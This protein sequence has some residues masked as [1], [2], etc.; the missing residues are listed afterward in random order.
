MSRRTRSTVSRIAACGAF[1][2]LLA[3]GTAGPVVA[4]D[5]G[6]A[7]KAQHAPEAAGAAQTGATRP[8]ATGRVIAHGGLL[9]RD[10]PTR[11]S[12]VIRHEPYGALVHIYCKTKGD[13]VDH[14]DR[15]YL[16]TDGTWAWGS[17]RYIENV[18]GVPRWC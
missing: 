18:A 2:A 7:A 3:L 4:D 9:L 14:N 8:T 1:C 10:A 6:G 11:G 16:L 5:N 17:A 12:A 13:N 15:W